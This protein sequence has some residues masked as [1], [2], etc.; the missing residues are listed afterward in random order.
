MNLYL[1][2]CYS[3]AAY[4]YRLAPAVVTVGGNKSKPNHTMHRLPI[5]PFAAIA[6][7]CLLGFGLVNLAKQDKQALARCENRGG[8]VAECR[9]VVLG[10]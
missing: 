1:T 7:G 6:L 9:L 8:S 2:K 3:K 5:K 10:R 4:P